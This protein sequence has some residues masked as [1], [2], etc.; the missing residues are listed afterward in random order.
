VTLVEL[1]NGDFGMTA[2]RTY[3]FG[4]FQSCLWTA[5]HASVD[6][7]LKTIA[8]K[9]IKESRYHV[10][11]AASWVLR[12]GDGTPDSHGRMQTTVE[13]LWPYTAELFTA[14]PVDEAIARS[15]IGPA[16]TDLHVDWSATVLPLLIEA[17]LAVPEPTSFRSRGKQGVHSEHLGPLLAEMQYLQRAYPDATW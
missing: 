13:L 8:Q 5:L 6:A 14:D 3:L 11:H 16:F 10:D 2:L 4:A 9:S 15:K 7:E 12:L 17:T 1:P